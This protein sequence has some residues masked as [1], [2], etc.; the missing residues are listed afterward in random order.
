[1]RMIPANQLDIL[2]ARGF[3]GELHIAVDP[4]LLDPLC[5]VLVV[6]LAASAEP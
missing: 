4:S 6:D 5:T 3:L 2:S 1:M